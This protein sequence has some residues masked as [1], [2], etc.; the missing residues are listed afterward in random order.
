MIFKYIEE[1][2]LN[3]L[4][5]NKL[6]KL[7]INV[8]KLAKKMGVGVEASNFNDEVSGLFVM[9]D[10]KPFIAYNLSQSRKRRRFTIAHELGH[11]ILHSKSKSLFIDKNNSVMY[12]NSES[13]TGEF[14]K[15]REANAF[16]AA[17]LMPIPLIASEIKD[18]DGDDIVEKLASK[19]NVS[20]QAMSFRLSNLGYDFGM[21]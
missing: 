18:L 10:D 17:L 4:L 20:T 5:E 6:L 16:A 1:K 8:D 14:L 9:K 21:F 3:I 15:E 11:Y 2:S 19:F 13:S 7:P 12:R